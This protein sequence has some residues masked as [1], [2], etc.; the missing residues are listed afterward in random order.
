M[1]TPAIDLNALLNMGMAGVVLASIVIPLLRWLL[2]ELTA[3]RL[4]FGQFMEAHSNME[5]QMLAKLESSMGLLTTTLAT[6]NS[7]LALLTTT[8]SSQNVLLQTLT[9]EHQSASSR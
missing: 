4:A 7:Q 5:V 2:H 1:T 6:Y 3:Q 9:R 8:I